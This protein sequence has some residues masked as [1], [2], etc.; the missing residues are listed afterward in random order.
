[1]TAKIK[2]ID[3]VKKAKTE[4]FNSLDKAF[5]GLKALVDQRKQ[6]LAQLKVARRH[7]ISELEEEEGAPE[8]MPPKPRKKKHHHAH[9]MSQRYAMPQRPQP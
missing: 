1:M 3:E 2:D 6:N 7:Q 4:S 5:D 8:D 9:S